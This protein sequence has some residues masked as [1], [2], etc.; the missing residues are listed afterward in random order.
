M[1]GARELL[2]RGGDRRFPL[3]DSGFDLARVRR[4]CFNSRDRGRHTLGQS[5]DQCPCFRRLSRGALVLP[6][7]G[8]RAIGGVRVL[9]GELHG[10]IEYWFA[11]VLALAVLLVRPQGL[12]GERLIERI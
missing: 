5:V 3:A 1:F 8:R 9:A 11:Y 10:G 7:E 4:D 2:A 12:F 6:G